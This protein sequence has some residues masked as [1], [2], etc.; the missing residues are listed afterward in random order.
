[1]EVGIFSEYLLIWV[2]SVLMVYGGY[3]LYRHTDTSKGYLIISLQSISYYKE[4]KPFQQILFDASVNADVYY[5]SI[6]STNEHGPLYGFGFKKGSTFI[7]FSGENGYSVPDVRQINPFIH[8]I[9]Q[10]N[11]IQMSDTMKEY[12]TK[13]PPIQDIHPLN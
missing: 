2:P 13:Y 9:V 1:M 8:T 10:S 11:N 6:Y 3:L 4:D 12:W 7:E 5:N